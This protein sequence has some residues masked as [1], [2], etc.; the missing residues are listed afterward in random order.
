MKQSNFTRLQA[1]GLIDQKYK[2]TDE[3]RGVIESLSAEE[4]ETI[5]KV[6]HKLDPNWST[7]AEGFKGAIRGII[8]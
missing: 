7:T 4:V 3:D 8:L 5:I 6:V 2:F 1:E